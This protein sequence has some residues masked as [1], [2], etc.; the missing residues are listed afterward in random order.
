MKS[1]TDLLLKENNNI[2]IAAQPSYDKPGE[3]LVYISITRNREV[4]IQLFLTTDEATD[5]RDAIDRSIQQIKDP[6]GSPRSVPD[7]E[8]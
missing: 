2:G 8:S 4:I 5:L 7:G 6:M 1:R 3:Q